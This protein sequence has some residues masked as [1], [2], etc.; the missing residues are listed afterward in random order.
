M[1]NIEK[2]KTPFW[3]YTQ[4]KILSDLKTGKAGIS[5]NT[6]QQRLSENQPKKKIKSPFLRDVILFFNQFK[7]PLV[8][9]L[10][11]AVILSAFL[12][13]TSDVFIIL[14]ILIATGLLSFWQER[15]AGRA[16]EKLQSLIQ[17]TCTVIRDGATKEIPSHEVVYGDLLI[18]KS[19]DIV[20]ADCYLIELNELNVN[21]ASLTGESFPVRK[22]LDVSDEAAAFGVL[23]VRFA[24][25]L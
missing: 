20:P 21:E 16:V 6:A 19:G 8:L 24:E 7:S 13:E 22:T 18:F 23:Q 2:L 15:N 10:V 11:V 3:S 9:L 12:G 1:P 14:F 4:E 5:Q 17:L 25:E